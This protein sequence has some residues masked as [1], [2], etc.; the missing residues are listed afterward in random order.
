MA[1]SKNPTHSRGIAELAAPIDHYSS[2]FTA[3]V[4][5]ISS[6][7]RCGSSKLDFQNTWY[8]C[9]PTWQ[10]SQQQRAA[11][12]ASAQHARLHRRSST[13][14]A[15]SWLLRARAAA[16]CWCAAAYAAA[17]YAV[18]SPRLCSRP[19]PCDADQRRSSLCQASV[20]S[21]SAR[22]YAAAVRA[23]W[24]ARHSIARLA[25]ASAASRTASDAAT[26]DAH[27]S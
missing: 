15:T 3:A 11:L 10:S 16:T 17:V 4:S 21:A 12:T 20:R 25:A 7:N 22:S 2:V 1:N 24:R 5:S 6:C 13:S 26:A 18:L 14:R 27:A 23:S 9:K 8:C 19:T